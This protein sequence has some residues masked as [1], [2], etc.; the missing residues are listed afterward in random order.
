MGGFVKEVHSRVMLF[1]GAMGH[2]NVCLKDQKPILSG[3]SHESQSQY[4]ADQGNEQNDQQKN[5][6]VGNIMAEIDGEVVGSQQATG[7][8]D[9]M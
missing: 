8:P 5:R 2:R 4:P 9:F 1:R 7:A 6:Q 3:S